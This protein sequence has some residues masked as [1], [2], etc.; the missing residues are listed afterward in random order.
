M[1]YEIKVPQL[2]VNDEFVIIVEWYVKDGE[3]IQKGQ[4]ICLVETSKTTSEITAEE[5]G[6]IK[7]DK[8]ELEEAKI[9]EIIGYITP[10]KTEK[11]EIKEIG[12]ASC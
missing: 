2:G 6:F 12:R 4:P 11:I 5:T 10:S 7:I 3:R 1:T 8:K 9:K